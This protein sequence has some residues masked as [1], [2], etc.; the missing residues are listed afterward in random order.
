MIIDNVKV[1]TEA[2]KF[3]SGGI[4]TQGD[5]IAKIYA[6][7]EKNF[8]FKKMNI[9][10]E[11][12]VQEQVRRNEIENATEDKANAIIDGKGA[13]AIP[14]LI[15]LHFHGCVGDDFCDGDKEAIRRIAEYEVSV[16]VTAIAPATMT[17]PVEE[18]ENIL[19]TAVAYKKE[20]KNNKKRA[21]FVGINM[22]G[23]FISPE[24][25]GAQD[26][27]NIIPCNEEVAEKFLSAS[28]NLVKFI[29]VAPEESENAISFIKNMKD[30]V[31]ISL[32]HTNAN[33]ESA[34]EAFDAGANHAVHL[35]N[36][37][38]A[39]TH[40]EPG[41]V[42]AISDSEHV[43]TEIICDG[44]HIHPS[45]VRAA[46][47]MMGAERMILIS[48]S[49]RATGMPDG[50]YTLGGLDVK[51][52]GNRATLVS[53]GALA[54]SVTN[55]ADC[56]RTAVTQM[57]IPLETAIACATKNPA[58]SLGIYDE[59]GSLSIGKKAD[60]VLLDENLTLQAV[61]KDGRL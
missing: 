27:K 43:M 57:G 23:P 4:I 50:Q 41:V 17:L 61:I 39:F 19:K 46:F 2:G 42:G 10:E 3:I 60:I 21:D 32:A 8:I 56:M 25:K 29:G 58:I 33:Y 20:Y 16:G 36:A 53:D 34:K 11:I 14:G 59:R 24:K 13:Y 28:D 18:L 45:M 48:D 47:K 52:R 5:K 51:V 37:M 26:E 15:D 6:E 40:R 1:Y 31:N 49:M 44:V 22:E 38:P 55:L 35:F 9:V 54:G 7:Q 30:R 12:S